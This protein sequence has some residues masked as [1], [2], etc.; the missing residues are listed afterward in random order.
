MNGSN[1]LWYRRYRAQQRFAEL[2]RHSEA[3]RAPNRVEAP[4]RAQL[5][6]ADD[7]IRALLERSRR[8][9]GLPPASVIAERRRYRARRPDFEPRARRRGGGSA[10]IELRSASDGALSFD[11]YASLTDVPYQVNDHLGEFTETM[12][13]GAFA[14]SL[15]NHADVVLL[16][17]HEGIPLARTKSGTMH[18]SEDSRGLHVS[19]GLEPRSSIV[20]NLRHSMARGDLDQMSF[21]F[22]CLHDEWNEDYTRRNVY[23]VALRDVSIVTFPASSSTTASI[24]A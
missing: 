8:Q 7:E 17:N 16:A 2:R 4:L 22:R 19:A 13:S 3:G 6:A 10:Q 20:N 12:R 23:D 5:Q 14:S 24:T 21:A 15:A 9:R 1:N 18:L 11:G